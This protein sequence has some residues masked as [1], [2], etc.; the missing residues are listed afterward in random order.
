MD[1]W[2]HVTHDV[3]VI[4]KILKCNSQKCQFSYS[5]DKHEFVIFVASKGIPINGIFSAAGEVLSRYHK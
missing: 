1:A 3:E 2:S 5:A 4:G